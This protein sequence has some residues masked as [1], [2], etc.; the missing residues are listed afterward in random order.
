M[1]FIGVQPATVPL[2]VNDVPDLPATK[3][4]SG[5]FP[6]LNGSNLTNLD[7]SDLTGT[8]PAISG[9]NLTNVSAGKL[10]Q[11]VTE[12]FSTDTE[13]STTSY[14]NVFSKSITPTLNTS[15]VLVVVSGGRWAL[16]GSPSYEAFYSVRRASTEIMHGLQVIRQVNGN[17]ASGTISVSYLDSPSSSSSISYSLD[18]KTDNSARAVAVCNAI[19]PITMTLMEIG[20]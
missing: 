14:S 1:G 2:S 12:K 15:K 3:I 13:I 17:I 6:A 18:A 9:A 11:V 7:A 10:L 5:T 20:A 8:L 16:Y 4:T 19:S